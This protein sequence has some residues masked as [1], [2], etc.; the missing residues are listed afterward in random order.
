MDNSF[1]AARPAFY[2]NY[3]RQKINMLHLCRKDPALFHHCFN[4]IM[5]LQSGM[6]PTECRKNY[7]SA[8]IY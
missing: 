5:Y 8:Y 4:Y 1:Y 3:L 6:N 7:K 2:K